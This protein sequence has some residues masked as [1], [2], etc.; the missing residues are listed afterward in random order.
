MLIDNSDKTKKS[1]KNQ[2]NNKRLSER[3]K[4]RKLAQIERRLEDQLY[5]E[6]K[7]DPETIEGQSKIDISRLEELQ[8]IKET[9]IVEDGQ[10][11]NDNKNK[12]NSEEETGFISSILNY[13]SLNWY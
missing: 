3:R 8:L 4:K 5:Q 13:I 11:N 9:K 6:A 12:K 10:L 2:R 1:Q 7:L